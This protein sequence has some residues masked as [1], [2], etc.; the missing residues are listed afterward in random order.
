MLHL[1]KP[2]SQ[3]CISTRPLDAS[4]ILDKAGNFTTILCLVLVCHIS[5]LFLHPLLF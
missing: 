1:G 3:Q 4:E 2:G 5:R